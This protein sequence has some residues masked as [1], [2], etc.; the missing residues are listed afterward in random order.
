MWD[1]A[2]LRGVLDYENLTNPLVILQHFEHLRGFKVQCDSP[3]LT[4]VSS[5]VPVTCPAPSLPRFSQFS[6]MQSVHLDPTSLI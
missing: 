4:D 2:G 1:Q 3:R 6:A 5:F